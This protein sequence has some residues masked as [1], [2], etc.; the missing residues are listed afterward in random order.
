MFAFRVS[1]K[2]NCSSTLCERLKKT[3]LHKLVVLHQ[4]YN[5]LLAGVCQ[6]LWRREL[7]TRTQQ[8]SK[9]ALRNQLQVWKTNLEHLFKL[10]RHT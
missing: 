7:N 3:V 1:I 9:K 4:S 6:K 8:L 5:L 2:W 10:Y